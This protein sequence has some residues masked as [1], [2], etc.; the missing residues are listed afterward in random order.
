MYN[1]IIQLSLRPIGLHDFISADDFEHGDI[2]DFAEYVS[3]TDESGRAEALGELERLAAH[4]GHVNRAGNFIQFSLADV[5]AKLSEWTRLM[6]SGDSISLRLLSEDL[7]YY[8]GSRIMFWYL[9]AFIPPAFLLEDI[10]RSHTPTA[11][12]IGGILDYK[13]Y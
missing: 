7:K 6:A 12:Y 13:S 8:E 5:I 4:I 11:L 1:Y 3:D 2:S 10:S 9:G